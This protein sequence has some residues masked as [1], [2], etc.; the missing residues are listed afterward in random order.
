MDTAEAWFKLSQSVRGEH[1]EV[2]RVRVLSFLLFGQPDHCTDDAWRGVAKEAEVQLDENNDVVFRQVV[3]L[4]LVDMV[5]HALS[6]I[7][8]HLDSTDQFLLGHIL[9]IAEQA[10]EH[11]LDNP[12]ESSW[13]TTNIQKLTQGYPGFRS[14]VHFAVLILVIKHVSDHIRALICD[15]RDL[16]GE[17]R[18]SCAKSEEATNRIKLEGNT[19]FKLE[20]DAGIPKAIG[21]YSSAIRQNPF[22]AILY[23]NRCICYLKQSKTMLALVDGKCCSVLAPTWER[24][25]HRYVQALIE[26]RGYAKAKEAIEAARKL[27]KAKSDLETQYRGILSA[28][29]KRDGELQSLFD[30]MPELVTDDEDDDMPELVTDDDSGSRRKT[31]KRCACSSE[32]ECQQRDGELQSPYDDMPELVTDD[33]DDCK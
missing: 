1:F 32:S 15:S 2:M 6:A 26:S 31:T 22:S 11:S 14:N 17:H 27:C 21:L 4:D 23:S 3:D 19:C 29:A 8:E 18:R 25:Q 20:L 13:F 24:G 28:I 5:Q 12:P 16:T 10:E 7:K 30:D 9:G 33:K